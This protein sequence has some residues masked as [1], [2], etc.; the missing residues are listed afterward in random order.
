MIPVFENLGER[1]I[2]K[3]SHPVI[4]LSVVRKVFQ[5]LAQNMI[6]DYL[7]NCC[8]FSD[9]QFEFRSSRSFTELLTV[10]SNI[11]TRA[12]NRSGAPRVETLDIS[13]AFDRVWHA[14]T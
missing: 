3:N 11:I 7:E 5:K 8:L 6:V 1:S 4:L 13:K 9:F 10:V 14:Q 12:F 2:A